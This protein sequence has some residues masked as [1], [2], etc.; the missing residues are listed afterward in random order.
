MCKYYIYAPLHESAICLCLHPGT[1]NVVFD[2]SPLSSI[3]V[4]QKDK[5]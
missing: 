2:G 3:S 5:L 4:L 1:Y